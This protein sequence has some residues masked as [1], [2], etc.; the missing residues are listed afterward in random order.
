MKLFF[1]F[2][3]T[4]VFGIEGSAAFTAVGRSP[5]FLTGA[6]TSTTLSSPRHAAARLP[7]ARHGFFKEIESFF[8][9]ERTSADEEPAAG[10]GFEP[11]VIDP[12][13]RLAGAFLAL[14]VLLDAV[15]YVQFTLGPLVTALGVLFLVQTFRLRFVFDEDNYFELKTASAGSDSLQDAGENIV[16]GGA[17]RWDCNTIVNYD[18]FPAGWIDKSP[19]GPILVYF[20]ETQTPSDTWNDGP[21]KSANDPEKIAS[22]RA[23]AGQVHFFPA[24]CNAKQM[25]EAFRVRGCRKLDY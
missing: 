18:F 2:L 8:G 14:G 15:P 12:D 5:K 25:E 17:N 6:G 11:V 9:P 1:A 23:I 19:I 7:T 4:L 13:F 24:V 21:G 10:P 16:V 3:L 22:G 20:K